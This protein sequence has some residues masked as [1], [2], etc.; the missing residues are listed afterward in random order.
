VDAED[1]ALSAG[2]LREMTSVDESNTGAG[3]VVSGPATAE[4]I[5][6]S[7]LVAAGAGGLVLGALAGSTV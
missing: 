2:V 3:V 6:G 4:V 7:A 1:A 5:K